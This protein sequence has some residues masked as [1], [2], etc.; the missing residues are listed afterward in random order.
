MSDGDKTSYR[1]AIFTAILLEYQTVCAHL[2]NLREERTTLETLCARGEFLANNRK[3]EVMIIQ[4][5]VGT[6]QAA[7]KTVYFIERFKPQVVI[8][9]G[10]AGG[11][12][13]VKLGDVVIASQVYNY[14]S[15]RADPSFQSRP[16]VYLPTPQIHQ[17]AAAAAQK[18]DWHRRLKERLSEPH[19][20]PDVF[21]A[22]IASGNQVVASTGAAVLQLVHSHFNDAAAIEMEGFGFLTAAHLYREIEALVIRG[23]SDLIDNKNETDKQQ[24]QQMAADRASAFAFEV[25]ANLDV[26]EQAVPTRKTT[27]VSEQQTDNTYPQETGQEEENQTSS[28]LEEFNNRLPDFIEKVKKIR[29]SLNRGTDFSA[30]QHKNALEGLNDIESHIKRLLD[31]ASPSIM[32]AKKM[33]L[34]AM[35]KHIHDL[36]LELEKRHHT[37]Q[38]T[39]S[40]QSRRTKNN[41]YDRAIELCDTLLEEDFKQWP[42]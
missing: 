41:E 6:A 2:T 20:E 25:L 21:I 15:G 19:K 39:R 12:K 5:G 42:R 30:D 33:M 16:R 29:D 18:K 32:T 34:V 24:F 38:M 7:A 22:P 27:I 9:V 31:A 26:V 14:E 35:Q 13:D 4:T 17:R 23:I 28:L 37:P 10:I 3:W 36:K 11:I 40:S 8:F 1:A